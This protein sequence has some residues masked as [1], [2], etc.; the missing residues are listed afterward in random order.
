MTELV[1]AYSLVKDTFSL[2]RWLICVVGVALVVRSVAA[3]FNRL[4]I[5]CAPSREA[6]LVG[7]MAIVMILFSRNFAYA[8]T[9]TVLVVSVNF[10]RRWE[11]LRSDDLNR[12][13]RRHG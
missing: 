1:E 9:I 3:L 6:L 5:S 2:T 11:Q 4:G 13:S 8:A 12:G 10:H 7:A